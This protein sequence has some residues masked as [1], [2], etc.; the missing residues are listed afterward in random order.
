MSR[1]PLHGNIT[2]YTWKRQRQLEKLP[3]L[4][5]KKVVWRR[6]QKEYEKEN[7][8]NENEEAGTYQVA[9]PLAGRLRNSL[10][11]RK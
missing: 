1:P 6:Q 11:S 4:P 9:H 2:L 7:E 5:P 8:N 3:Q 10:G